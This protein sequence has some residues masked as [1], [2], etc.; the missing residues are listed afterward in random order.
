MV[1]ETVLVVL[2]VVLLV[3]L[4]VPVDAQAARAMERAMLATRRSW[5]FVIMRRNLPD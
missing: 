1:V 5:I 3:V 4:R 2:R